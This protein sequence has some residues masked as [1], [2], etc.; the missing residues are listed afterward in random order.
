MKKGD[1]LCFVV[2]KESLSKASVA[3]S[4][5]LQAA[6]AEHSHDGKAK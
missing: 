4:S 6:L 1:S 2:L 5:C 3:V